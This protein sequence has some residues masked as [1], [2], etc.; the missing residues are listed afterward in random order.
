M[1]DRIHNRWII[2]TAGVVLQLALGAVYA[3][4]VFRIPLVRG[5]GWT[6]SEVTLTF[7]I[8]IF[9]L[10]IASFVGG[11]WMRAKG[12]RIVGIA[13]GCLYGLG[14]SRKLL[15]PWIVGSLSGSVASRKVALIR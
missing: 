3:W 11:L 1:P 12:P 10:G 15:Q 13:G 5:F 2:A 9:T 4:S 6:I 7:T 14:A 8:A